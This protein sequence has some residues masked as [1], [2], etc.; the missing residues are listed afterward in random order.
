[1]FRQA[2]SVTAPVLAIIMAVSISNAGF[3]AS[4]DNKFAIKD[5]GQF[6][7]EKYVEDRAESREAR[8]RYAGWI[9]GYLTG[10]NRF[11]PD[12]VDIAPWQPILVLEALLDQHCRKHPE[13]NF[14]QATDQM[15]QGLAPMRLRTVSD[16]V[17]L[18]WDGR[19]LVLYQAIL[20]RAQQSLAER[21]YF[22]GEINGA[23]GDD[24]AEAL[25]AFQNENSLPET[26]LPD[27]RTLMILFR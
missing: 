19:S 13:L 7:C 22:T 23:F 25:I 27:T 8:M 3:A 18:E 17:R 4:E 9:A 12:T 2:I 16:P 14:H 1:M 11:T 10:I 6:S 21:G 24:T 20:Q 5:V 26:G 15:I